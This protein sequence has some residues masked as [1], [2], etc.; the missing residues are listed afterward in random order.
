MQ[1]VDVLIVGGGPAGS[2]AAWQ[3]V[4]RGASVLVLDKEAFPRLKLCAGWITP[5]VVRDLEMDIKDYPHRFLTFDRLH[6]HVLAPAQFDARRERV[7]RGQR[8]S[9]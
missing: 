3:L 4:R 7:V 8:R 2:S 5:E 9:G 6:V 1:T